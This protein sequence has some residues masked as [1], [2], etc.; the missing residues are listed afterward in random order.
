MEIMAMDIFI[1]FFTELGVESRNDMEKM[2]KRK[3]FQ[4]FLSS[5]TEYKNGLLKSW[6]TFWQHWGPKDLPTLYENS[7]HDDWAWLLDIHENVSVKRFELQIE[8]LVFQIEEPVGFEPDV[9]FSEDLFPV[10]IGLVFF[11]GLRL[12]A[13]F[14][15]QQR[16]LVEGPHNRQ[17]VVFDTLKQLIIFSTPS[18]ERIRIAVD[19]LKISCW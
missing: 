16:L 10:W 15:D 5:I 13:G 19:S 14:V 12:V 4:I 2:S 7:R 6:M 8:S 9:T 18:P 3:K 11:V 17:I 1:V